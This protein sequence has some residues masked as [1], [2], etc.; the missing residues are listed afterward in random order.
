VDFLNR[1]ARVFR[2]S[3][4]S[5]AHPSCLFE[6]A[7][8]KPKYSSQSYRFCDQLAVKLPDDYEWATWRLI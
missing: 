7:L 6:S 3:E 5:M 1:A 8:Q 2:S 4:R